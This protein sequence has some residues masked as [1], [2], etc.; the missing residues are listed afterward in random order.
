MAKKK[1]GKKSETPK[2]PSKSK[3]VDASTP[4]PAKSTKKPVN[5]AKKAPASSKKQGKQQQQKKE[6]VKSDE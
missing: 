2:S 6:N 5:S 4:K 1:A 3:V